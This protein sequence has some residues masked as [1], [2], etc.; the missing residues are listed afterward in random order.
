MSIPPVCVVGL[1]LIII[2]SSLVH[3]SDSWGDYPN[4]ENDKNFNYDLTVICGGCDSSTMATGIVFRVELKISGLGTD[5][6]I[7]DIANTW[8]LLNISENEAGIRMINAYVG[9][10]RRDTDEFGNFYWEGT[11][12]KCETHYENDTIFESTD[13]LDAIG[14]SP[15]GMSSTGYATFT[16]PETAWRLCIRKSKSYFNE[17]GM[18]NWGTEKFQSSWNFIGKTSKTRSWETPTTGYESHIPNASELYF[19]H[20]SGSKFYSNDFIGFEVI[21]STSYTDLFSFNPSTVHQESSW[22]RDIAKL[23]PATATCLSESSSLYQSGVVKYPGTHSDAMPVSSFIASGYYEAIAYGSTEGG[24][25]PS[26]GTNEHVPW[27]YDKTILY[28]G[29]PVVYIKLPSVTKTTD[30]KLCYSASSERLSLKSADVTL[31]SP[32]WRVL[33]NVSSEN[34]VLITVYPVPSS[35]NQI[36]TVE[37]SS[38]DLTEKSWGILKFTK[39]Y[40]KFT[41]FLS[42]SPSQSNSHFTHVGGDAFRV[43]PYSVF[44]SYP[45][46]LYDTASETL[47][48]YKGCWHSDSDLESFDLGGNPREINFMKVDEEISN[49]TYGYFKVPTQSSFVCYRQ[50]DDNWRVL[51][52]LVHPTAT[53]VNVT[54]SINDTRGG[55]FAPVVLFDV[56]SSKTISPVKNTWHEVDTIV[57]ERSIAVKIISS[58]VNG[59]CLADNPLHPLSETW[60]ISQ[61]NSI[62][63][64]INKGMLTAWLLLPPF[65]FPSLVSGS[66]SG[67]TDGY[68]VC[69][70]LGSRNWITIENPN[71]FEN[72]YYRAPGSDGVV[73]RQEDSFILRTS[74]EIQLYASVSELI[75]SSI[76]LVTL[77]SHKDKYIMNPNDIISILQNESF[78]YLT[79]LESYQTISIPVT[80]S[81]GYS[82]ATFSVLLPKQ[83]GSRESYSLCYFPFG[84][85]NVLQLSIEVT[86]TNERTKGLTPSNGFT[87]RHS[88]SSSRSGSLSEIV[89]YSDFGHSLQSSDSFKLVLYKG[90]DIDCQ[91]QAVQETLTSNFQLKTSLNGSKI[92]ISKYTNPVHDFKIPQKMVACYGTSQSWFQMTPSVSITSS[93]MMYSIL[94]S[95]GTDTYIGG[96]IV[97]V[98]FSR[99]SCPQCVSFNPDI[100]FAE[101]ISEKYFCGSGSP[102]VATNII[103]PSG[104]KNLQYSLLTIT[105]PRQSG[106]YRICYKNEATGGI[107]LEIKPLNS[108]SLLQIIEEV[109]QASFTGSSS[110]NATDVPTA[111]VA[112]SVLEN[113]IKVDGVSNSISSDTDLFMIVSEELPDSCTDTSINITTQTSNLS[114][115]TT[116]SMTISAVVPPIEGKYTLC[117]Y[118]SRVDIWISVGRIDVVQSAVY[119][120]WNSLVRKVSLIDEWATSVPIPESAPSISAISV[121]ETEIP[122][123]VSTADSIKVIS[124]LTNPLGCLSGDTSLHPL[125][126]SLSSSGYLSQAETLVLSTES[127][128]SN[129]F[130]VVCYIRRN[131][132]VGTRI[133][134]GVWIQIPTLALRNGESA[135]LGTQQLTTGSEDF[136]IKSMNVTYEDLEI[137]SNSFTVLDN[138]TNDVVSE[139]SFFRLSFFLLSD[140]GQVVV[141]H[142]S[143]YIIVTLSGKSFLRNSYS[144]TSQTCTDNNNLYGWGKDKTFF[145]KGHA[146]VVIQIPHGCYYEECVVKGKAISTLSD[147]SMHWNG[148]Q[149]APVILSPS[150]VNVIVPIPHINPGNLY[151]KTLWEGQSLLIKSFLL[152]NNS[153]FAESTSYPAWVFFN[154]S[155]SSALRQINI[156]CV[157][158]CASDTGLVFKS[159]FKKGELSS[160]FK[161]KP[162]K[163]LMNSIVLVFNVGI[164]RDDGEWITM[165][166]LDV[167]IKPVKAERIISLNQVPEGIFQVGEI[168]DFELRGENHEG[169]PVSVDAMLQ[170]TLHIPPISGRIVAVPISTSSPTPPHDKRNLIISIKMLQGCSKLSKCKLT[171][172]LSNGNKFSN[173]SIFVSIRTIS[174]RLLLLSEL[175]N[176]I[177]MNVYFETLV[178]TAVD[179]RGI[180]DDGNQG[181]G[182]V[183]LSD[184]CG[185]DYD[186]PL[187]LGNLTASFVDGIATFKNLRVTTP[188]QRCIIS[189]RNSW[190]GSILSLSPFSVVST[191]DRIECSADPNPRLHRASVGSQFYVIVRTVSSTGLNIRSSIS[192]KLSG[193]SGVNL[194]EE[195]KNYQ[196]VNGMV[197]ILAQFA[198]VCS[199]CFIKFSAPISSDSW[200]QLETTRSCELT[201]FEIF[202]RPVA[203]QYLIKTLEGPGVVAQLNPN[204]Y[205]LKTKEQVTMTVFAADAYK[206]PDASYSGQSKRGYAVLSSQFVGNKATEGNGGSLVMSNVNHSKLGAPFVKGEAVFH[207]HIT[208]P[209][210][211]CFIS[212]EDSAKVVSGSKIAVSLRPVATS[213]F[214]KPDLPV[215]DTN[216]T[217]LPARGAYPVTDPLINLQVYAVDD[218]GIIDYSLSARV[219]LR[220]E[221]G[222]GVQRFT[223]PNSQCQDD[224]E[225]VISK[226]LSGTSS[227][228]RRLSDVLNGNRSGLQFSILGLNPATK[229]DSLSR[230]MW[231]RLKVMTE[232]TNQL[233]FPLGSYTFPHSTY[234][235]AP[236]L[237]SRVVVSGVSGSSVQI[238]SSD[239]VLQSGNPSWSLQ[240]GT[241]IAKQAFPVSVNVVDSHG[242]P[243]LSISGIVTPT[244]LSPTTGCNA[245]LPLLTSPAKVV[246]GASIVWLHFGSPCENCEIRFSLLPDSCTTVDCVLPARYSY[247]DV[248]VS[249]KVGTPQL[250]ALNHVLPSNMLSVAVGVPISFSSVLK[251]FN[252]I[253]VSSPSSGVTLHFSVIPDPTHISNQ[254]YQKNRSLGIEPKSHFFTSAETSVVLF[255]SESCIACRI[256]VR[257]MNVPGG[258]L[259][260]REFYLTGVSGQVF[261]IE[262]PFKKYI[263][264][265]HPKTAIRLQAF[266]VVLEAIDGG[267]NTVLQHRE[268]IDSRR[269]LFVTNGS[270]L[271]RVKDSTIDN[272]LYSILLEVSH[273]CSRCLLSLRSDTNQNWVMPIYASASTLMITITSKP[274]F[275][276]NQTLMVKV[277]AVDNFGWRDFS[278]GGDTSMRHLFARYSL[279]L[280]KG[281]FQVSEGELLL[282]R[283]GEVSI[284]GSFTSSGVSTIS[285]TCCTSF[286]SN[287]QIF[288]ESKKISIMSPIQN[289]ILF[290]IERSQRRLSWG[291]PVAFLNWFAVS[292]T[293]YEPPTVVYV[294]KS[295][296]VLNS[297][298]IFAVRGIESISNNKTIV[299]E[300]RSVMELS[301][302][303]TATTE[304]ICILQINPGI[305]SKGSIAISLIEPTATALRLHV[306]SLNVVLGNEVNI[307]VAVEDS[308]GNTVHNYQMNRI[309]IDVSIYGS[310]CDIPKQSISG[311]YSHTLTNTSI[312]L[313]SFNAVGTCAVLFKGS[314][315][316]INYELVFVS[317]EAYSAVVNQVSDI[318]VGVDAVFIVSILDKN[319]NI[320]LGDRGSSV[321]IIS[322]NGTCDIETRSENTVEGEST[323]TVKALQP[324][325]KNKKCSFSVE[326][327]LTGSNRLI[328]GESDNFTIGIQATKLVNDLPMGVD[329]QG[330]KQAIIKISAVDDF[331]NV[332]SSING[333]QFTAVFISDEDDQFDPWKLMNPLSS[334][335]G[336]N[337]FN[338][339][340]ELFL[341]Q[342]ND[343]FD[344]VSNDTSTVDIVNWFIVRMDSFPILKTNIVWVPVSGLRLFSNQQLEVFALRNNIIKLETTTASGERHSGDYFTEH[345]L[346]VSNSDN[347]FIVGNTTNVIAVGGVVEFLFRLE[348]EIQSG[349]LDLEV[350]NLTFTVQL[351]G[352]NSFT[353]TQQILS[354][355][356]FVLSVQGTTFD[357]L[358]F[359]SVIETTTAVDVSHMRIDKLCR[360]SIKTGERISCD[361]RTYRVLQFAETIYKVFFTVSSSNPDSVLFLLQDAV[362]PGGSESILQQSFKVVSELVTLPPTPEPVL[363]PWSYSS[364]GIYYDG[365]V[366][367]SIASVDRPHYVMIVLLISVLCLH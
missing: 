232:A 48:P 272:G 242:Y 326:I 172:I 276:V 41:S 116:T 101:I 285:V 309:S 203:T 39:P 249:V 10:G 121:Q 74:A 367:S 150:M 11:Q 335:F 271:I 2:T 163:P 118:Y 96:S 126:S 310:V 354:D 275:Y 59:N 303:F 320:V 217:R 330:T 4:P 183:F 24:F 220:K 15:H 248:N 31:Q 228:E 18:D 154:E 64:N 352:Y 130:N 141:D 71:Y 286:T 219:Y 67:E 149:S 70:K 72:R 296:V 68:F 164:Y 197:H 355:V 363:P 33:S 196:L 129:T 229:D 175:S 253:A 83:I 280:P 98:R 106:Q 314:L 127:W 284:N 365:P 17:S 156:N 297:S 195:N 333:E 97:Q 295:L 145:N 241:A 366:D 7:T 319:N 140:R 279:I 115:S 192:V 360:H 263:I 113:S 123:K 332:D 293:S 52:S 294:K 331:G 221:G 194:V 30:Y 254:M 185:L 204:W 277:T 104:Y 353:L 225:E 304:K 258:G 255:F 306:S 222:V 125:T 267:G 189:V 85:E 78:C 361:S 34:D 88:V 87:V 157:G 292:I 216:A 79:P 237:P 345:T 40:S 136:K 250:V 234:W 131:S 82:T 230:D 328:H 245:G 50:Q 265:Y 322:N 152:N 337:F 311:L 58:Y 349:T 147:T 21:G 120:L 201:S 308:L 162:T 231:G 43:V 47:Y 178:I 206:T 13:L 124:L 177:G 299:F 215:N 102:R 350:G 60:D 246:N 270:V 344:S 107:W 283:D 134:S 198:S 90:T 362:S 84:S 77:K 260:E 53:T 191:I 159:E 239:N 89:F 343:D 282:F 61:Y 63:T 142:W 3:G 364:E 307:V 181:L 27:Q 73:Y 281:S 356:H 55:T 262:A 16:V 236:E 357:P 274:P 278:V 9:G 199:N 315:P 190:G 110:Y 81:S 173:C 334:G 289:K 261:R 298:C 114:S 14:T 12:T 161:L 342:P 179:G 137:L 269:S 135:S 148:I 94:P 44:F 117:Y 28:T 300:E 321:V 338:G 132:A 29:V 38:L 165:G 1:L 316:I 56:V 138:Y 339:S 188:C 210:L 264:R 211:Q 69:L 251:M 351:V 49:T 240:D 235:R 167:L 20:S 244:L 19:R 37:W 45:S 313:L 133:R 336:F 62:D 317:Q 327:H 22:R 143:C 257:P 153:V 218:A 301:V 99:S 86:N 323:V 76:T 103:R 187:L 200:T 119:Y 243:S 65:S 213:L 23:I 35:A 109:R 168:Y 186:K 128:K 288:G 146:S 169:I 42:S 66:S 111:I 223:C 233:G 214:I 166:R 227:I 51:G 100:D 36:D 259:S 205:E 174:S 182:T 95:L 93:F 6:N 268:F 46:Q 324:T 226:W 273:P 180:R 184:C 329:V 247:V 325:F 252:K 112:G 75:E 5:V 8:Q 151:Y 290:G 158:G 291:S 287:M 340:G 25:S 208:S 105:L 209:C 91:Q 170:H 224:G 359:L 92:A 108:T 160:I 347:S 358:L 318:V 155:H 305:T 346:M 139:G 122:E 312:V 144:V 212:F 32:G 207:F 256:A 266:S 238:V 202:S 171:V 348:T 193:S 176:M 341:S 302:R 54:Y 80:D 26:V 57:D